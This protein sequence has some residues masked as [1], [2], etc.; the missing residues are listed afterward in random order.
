M[1]TE[2]VTRVH[3][4]AVLQRVSL[5]FRQQGMIADRVSPRIP[6]E[7]QSD[8]YRIWGRDM[9]LDHSAGMNW[10]PGTIPNEITDAWSQDTYFAKFFKLRI[11]LLDAEKNNEDVGLNLRQRRTQ[12]LTGASQIRREARLATLFRTA[13]NYSGSNVVTKAGGAEWNTVLAATPD[14]TVVID[15]IETGIARAKATT[16]LPTSEL[17]VI[18]PDP[19]FDGTMKR[20][21]AILERIKYS[22]RG[23]VTTDLI[24]ELLGVKEVIIATAFSAQG[25]KID[26][27]NLLTGYTAAPLWGDDVWIG[28]LGVAGQTQE[29]LGFS[30]SFNYTKETNGQEREIREYRM[31][32]EGQE[33]DW[34]EVKEAV[35]EK[36]TFADAGYL[37][38]NTLSTI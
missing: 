12:R 25:P 1:S 18:V 13:A 10:A 17:S 9:F 24:K 4:P 31:A 32:D 3:T 30:Y 8:I 37:I 5:A 22:E 26:G 7:K 6:V 38:K 33:G 29:E 15:D 27:V 2:K 28:K 16:L 23:V 36:I 21:R 20:N 34:I 11:A 14:S 19:V 35:D